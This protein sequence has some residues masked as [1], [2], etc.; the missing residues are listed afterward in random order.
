VV[1]VD[2]MDSTRTGGL[3]DWPEGEKPTGPVV[4]FGRGG[5]CAFVSDPARADFT[6]KPINHVGSAA[7]YGD[8]TSA[9]RLIE[10][11]TANV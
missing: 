7:L 6:R 4:P 10:R 11:P 2:R 9:D 8:C 3:P 5:L 1:D